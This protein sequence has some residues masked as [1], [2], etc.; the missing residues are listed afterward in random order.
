MSM[1]LDVVVH[2]CN[3]STWE[4]EAG[5]WVPFLIACKLAGGPQHGIPPLSAGVRGPR[6]SFP[7]VTSRDYQ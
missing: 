5:P 2:A 7:A 1:S 3:T 6:I 4:T